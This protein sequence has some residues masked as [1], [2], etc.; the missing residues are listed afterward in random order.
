MQ[1]GIQ[2]LSLVIFYC[3]KLIFSCYCVARLTCQYVDQKH[4]IPW[5]GNTIGKFRN[6]EDFHPLEREYNRKISKCRGFSSFGKGIWSETSKRSK[7]S[8]RKCWKKPNMFIADVK[9]TFHHP[10]C[11]VRRHPMWLMK[12][13]I[14]SCNSVCTLKYK[15]WRLA[16]GHAGPKTL[17]ILGGQVD[18][19]KRHKTIH[20]PKGKSSRRLVIIGMQG[21]IL[22]WCYI[23]HGVKHYL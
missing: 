11:L 4:S 3:R 1:N 21:N 18:Y 17:L 19:K 10:D 12:F 23:K 16:W 2:T 9:I 8:I 22:D 20:P 7:I 13:S 6:V 14:N 15:N 5:K